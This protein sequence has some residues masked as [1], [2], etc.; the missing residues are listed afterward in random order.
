MKNK[1]LNVLVP[2]A[3][4]FLF[5]FI[6]G[7]AAS[8][9]AQSFD[10]DKLRGKIEKYT[11]ILNMKIEISFGMQTNEQEQRVLGTIVTEKGL[12]I[13]DGSFLDTRN[14]LSAL[15]GITI[16]TTP[17]KIEVAT[18][19]GLKYEG[20]YI[21]VDNFTQL[22]LVKIV[23]PE[24]TSPGLSFACV[25]FVKNYKFKVG[26]W[27]ALYMLLP[28]FVDP[29]LAADVGM[30]SSLI[31][32]PE[33]FP[34]TVGFSGLETASVLYN[35]NLLPVG[36]LGSLINP[37][38]DSD[39]GFMDSFSD[40]DY[41]LLG[42][43]TGE[44][45]EKIITHPPQKGEIERA[46][47]GITLQS[48][49]SDIA[50]FFNIDVPGGIIVNE[51]VKGSPA[52]KAGL[53]VGDMIIEINGQPVMV[54]REELL[55]IFQRR[56]SEMGEGT[57]V[58]FTVLRPVDNRVDSLKVFTQLESRPLAASEA[59]EYENKTLEFKV[60]NLVFSDYLYYNMDKDELYGAVVSEIKMGGLANIGG[61]LIGDIIQRIGGQIVTSVT[62]VN[63]FM[64]E[65]EQEKASEVIFFV[66]RR[67]KTM[68][69]NIKT[70]WK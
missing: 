8:A 54:D 11:V 39:I 59:E 19:T 37:S 70:D 57:R 33:D 36:V 18:L 34:L 68:F 55:P 9:G 43:I 21:G 62:D 10:F 3:G 49:T 61:L 58:E 4:L 66:W 60:R 29:P 41:P 6:M 14:P 7:L 47:L 1:P 53:A 64:T 48:L 67:N 69:V 26:D 44:R 56:I 65:M 27:M 2:I 15:S 20:E 40:F 13:F 50:A 25:N 63:N 22:G 35:E 24:G 12:V 23:V 45:L 31:K 46:W 16:K 38:T 28:K 17:V 32:T 30:I 52:D 5:S 51:V 42:I